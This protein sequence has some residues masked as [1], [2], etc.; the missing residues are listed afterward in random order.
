MPIIIFFNLKMRTLINQT[1]FDLGFFSFVALIRLY[2]GASYS[3]VRFIY[4][5]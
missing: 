2:Q 1:S 5:L 3:I 4:S